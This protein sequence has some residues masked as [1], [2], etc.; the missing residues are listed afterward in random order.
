MKCA[1][2][3]PNSKEVPQT[4]IGFIGHHHHFQ[5]KSCHRK[6]NES[7]DPC[8][9]MDELFRSVKLEDV[10]SGNRKLLKLDTTESTVQTLL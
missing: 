7:A 3:S 10:E 1:A 5:N 6:T 2:C 8:G 4:E 9:G